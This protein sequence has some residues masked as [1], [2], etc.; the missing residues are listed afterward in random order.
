MRL[1]FAGNW[2]IGLEGQFSGSTITGPDVDQRNATWSLRNDMDWYASVTGRL[3]WAF[4]HVLLHG[5]G[6]AAWANNKL[7]VNADGFDI[8][9]SSLVLGYW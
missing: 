3:G 2:V 1:Q 7:I 8:G 6:G 5:R 9:T 4:D